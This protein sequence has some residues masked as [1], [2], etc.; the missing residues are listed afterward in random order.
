ME[1]K[2]EPLSQTSEIWVKFQDIIYNDLF[3]G[4]LPEPSLTSSVSLLIPNAH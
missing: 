1:N 4:L 3:I 2:D